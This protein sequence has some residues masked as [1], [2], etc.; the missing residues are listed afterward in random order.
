M[1]R[2]WGGLAALLALAIL[3]LAHAPA[4]AGGP[5]QRI[6]SA[7]FEPADRGAAAQTV[8]LPDTWDQRGVDRRLQARYRFVFTL[9]AVPD[10]SMALAFTRLS[11]RHRIELN[12]H[13]V[14]DEG[15]A[16]SNLGLP[17]P[18]LIELAPALLRAGR[19]QVEIEVSHMR[20]GGLSAIELGPLAALRAPHQRMLLLAAEL[21]RA[22]NMACV[23]L[24]LLL[25][26]IWWRRRVEVALGSF[27]LLALIGSLRNYGYTMGV[28]VSG[29]AFSADWMLV[30]VNAWVAALFGVF[31]VA[32]VGER[33]P[34][35]RRWLVGVA[36]VV[37][38]LAAVAAGLDR[39]Q[40]LRGFVYPVLLAT[41][42]P[43]VWLCVARPREGRA[44]AALGVGAMLLG[45][46]HDYAYQAAGWLPVTDT[47]WMPYLMPLTLGTVALLLVRRMVRALGEVETLNTELEARVAART[48]QLERANA[49]KTH[50]LAA[51]S[52]D[53][54]QP[55]VT[56]GLLVGLAR[57]QASAGPVQALL[58]R[59]D[60]AVGAMERLLSG[61]LDLSRFEAGAVQPHPAPL[62]LGE[63]FAAIDA[64]E[65]VH[66][67]HKHLR[68]RLRPTEL[69]VHSD[70]VLL[71]RI[72]RNLVGNAL[73][74]TTRG[75]V[76]VAARRRGE[77][78]RIEVRDTGVGIAPEHQ[79][80]I[81]EEFVQVQAPAQGSTLGMG[82]G[83]AIVRRSAT[84]LGHRIG[85]VSTPGRG[86]CF[87]IELPRVAAAPQ[88]PPRDA[89]PAATLPS[90]LAGRRV[91]LID[92][93]D[94]VRDAIR[95][96]LQAWGAQVQAFAD[97]ES[98][99]RWLDG[100]RCAAPEL[101]LSDYRLRQGDGLLAIEMVRQRH[102]AVTSVLITGDSAPRDLAR[103]HAAGVRV[104]HKPFRT[105]ALLDV[106]AA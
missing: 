5:V 57:E 69:R 14:A 77:H 86:S 41:V 53:L 64:S 56:I 43:G 79:Q 31:A 75:G 98:L 8:T 68:L 6:E 97:I 89:E 51:A 15:S 74:Y 104:L 17:Q 47:F 35:Y 50:F 84:M 10:E 62:H 95:D 83:L 24:A 58:A 4:R 40:E 12:G 37:P 82:L 52:H 105:E 36:V 63:I 23:G 81:F 100:G 101:V 48:H 38:A 39:L 71:E 49:A 80:S 3:A 103:L 11:T 7:E 18:A 66:A 96:R 55:M 1:K 92:D 33:W 42:M 19:N 20:N 99:Q 61:L 25:I 54:R 32:L 46:L 2:T 65:Q 34:R 106:L 78:V 88:A 76:L 72:L 16:P 90:Q 70:R 93:E 29:N 9:A 59:V 21:P 13:V 91:L 87:W 22:L 102:G 44:L 85:L 45:A 60:E 94:T 73:R 27:G 67:T 26:A 28:S 30:A